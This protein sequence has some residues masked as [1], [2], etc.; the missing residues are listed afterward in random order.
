[1]PVADVRCR[2]NVVLAV[3]PD[4]RA[5]LELLARKY[6]DFVRS[7]SDRELKTLAAAPGHA[8]AWQLSG[9]QLAANGLEISEPETGEA[10]TNNTFTAGSRITAAAR[11]QTAAA[12]VVVER[13]AV[14]GLT[15]TQLADYVAMRA[16]TRADPARLGG[17]T[18]PT[19]LTVLDAAPDTPQPVTLTS[20]DLNFLKALYAAPANLYAPAQRAQISRDMSRGIQRQAGATPPR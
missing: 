15:V 14:T 9:P 8:A 19:I 13:A 20:W 16:F 7:L 3:V 4:K 1:M 11:P 12:M 5:F 18:A 17:T 2:P 10:A 6:P